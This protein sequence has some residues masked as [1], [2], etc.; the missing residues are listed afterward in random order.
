MFFVRS[1]IDPV[2]GLQ[3]RILETAWMCR[4]IYPTGAAQERKSD[5]GRQDTPAADDV[6]KAKATLPAAMIPG[7]LQGSLRCNA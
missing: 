4:C 1:S 2:A 6:V 3:V 5:N 7:G